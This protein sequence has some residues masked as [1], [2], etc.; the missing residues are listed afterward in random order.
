MLQ[1]KNCRCYQIKRGID[2]EELISSE[3]HLKTRRRAREFFSRSRGREIAIPSYIAASWYR[4]GKWRSRG[5]RGGE[6][7][8]RRHERVLRRICVYKCT[9]APRLVALTVINWPSRQLNAIRW[10]LKELLY[11]PRIFEG[12]LDLGEEIAVRG[13]RIR[14]CCGR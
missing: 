11:A 14:W 9:Y 3:K 2:I 4:L 13:E 7:E 5:R 6:G 10:S 12:A 8:R 1:L